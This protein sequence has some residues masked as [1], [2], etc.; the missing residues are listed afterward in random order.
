[1]WVS[2]FLQEGLLA[3]QRG[4][5]RFTV[6]SA[7]FSH[8]AWSLLAKDKSN[9]KGQSTLSQ[10]QPCDF[11]GSKCGVA[12]L[13]SSFRHHWNSFQLHKTCR[14]RFT[15]DSDPEATGGSGLLLGGAWIAG[16]GTGWVRTETS[17]HFLSWGS[18]QGSLDCPGAHHPFRRETN[19]GSQACCR[20][21]CSLSLRLRHSHVKAGL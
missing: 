14:D 9:Y 12:S 1:M 19:N 6:C 21:G 5:P 8:K 13:D 2:L 10:R 3:C 15:K 4:S 17:Q 20:Q 16:E 11:S 7:C 18:R